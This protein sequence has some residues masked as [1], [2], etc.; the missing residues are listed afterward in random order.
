MSD[1][2]AWLVWWHYALIVV[3]GG[4]HRANSFNAEEHSTLRCD[5]LGRVIGRYRLRA[6][7]CRTAQHVLR[8]RRDRRWHM[9]DTRDPLRP[10]TRCGVPFGLGEDETWDGSNR[11]DLTRCKAC[12]REMKVGA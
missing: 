9:V 7:F 11:P 4:P 6:W 10:V 1:R 8:W 5:D 12:L 3:R 2:M